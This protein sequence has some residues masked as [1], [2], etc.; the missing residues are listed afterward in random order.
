M[1]ESDHQ[2]DV[3]QLI[4]VT[5]FKQSTDDEAIGLYFE[6]GRKS[7]GGE[8]EKTERD[9]KTG[10]IRITFKDQSG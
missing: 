7:G 2:E 8:I 1:P 10:A 3:E 9:S 4:E 6:N 5:G